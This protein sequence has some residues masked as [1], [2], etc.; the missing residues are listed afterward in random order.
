VASAPTFEAL[1]EAINENEKEVQEGKS[2]LVMSNSTDR[3][4]A[5]MA[6]KSAG[7]RIP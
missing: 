5:R 3:Q 1:M 6:A 2:C 4:T 7:M